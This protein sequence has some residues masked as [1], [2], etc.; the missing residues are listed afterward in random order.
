MRSAALLIPLAVLASSCFDGDERTYAFDK[1]VGC[2]REAGFQVVDAP[3]FPPGPEWRNETPE[4][5]VRDGS[6][7]V[8]SIT[9]LKTVEQAKKSIAR[10]LPVVEAMPEVEV[11]RRGNVITITNQKDLAP[12]ISATRRDRAAVDRC[13]PED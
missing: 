8:Y 1:T 2:L 13:L 10:P 3:S 5:L 6:R 7:V 9:F 12:F 11:E 4:V